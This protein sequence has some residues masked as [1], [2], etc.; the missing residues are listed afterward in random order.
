MNGAVRSSVRMIRSRNKKGEDGFLIDVRVWLAGGPKL[1]QRLFC[2]GVK[3]DA[4]V[5]GNRMLNEMS[6]ALLGGAAQE[7]GRL[8]P[9]EHRVAVAIPPSTVPR[10][11]E[12][13][14]VFLRDYV[15]ANKRAASTYDSYEY[16]LRLYIV[17]LI[18]DLRLNEVGRPA[19]TKLKAALCGREA[20]SVNDVLGVLAK[21]LDFAVSEG[22][23][24]AMPFR[25]KDVKLP[26]VHHQ[27]E[28]YDFAEFERLV[29]A[30][31]ALGPH[32]Y[33][34]VLLGGEAGL[35]RGE[36]AALQWR[37]IDLKSGRL[38]VA[39]SLYKGML[40]PPKGRKSRTMQ[41][42]ERLRGALTTLSSRFA[43]ERVVL[44]AG[45]PCNLGT[46]NEILGHVSKAAG[47]KKK[48]SRKV[49]I[50][51]HTFCSHLAMRGATAVQIQQLAGH[52][53]LKTTQGY[54][55]LAPGHAD[56]AIELLNGRA[57]PTKQASALVTLASAAQSA[58]MGS[59][60]R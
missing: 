7:M 29:E 53:D 46:V 44:H 31:F 1:R 16:R 45:K 9:A 15:R 52:V 42:T 26:E 12:F 20:G 43:G 36:I 3:A 25:L 2:E 13:A 6:G 4:T 48:G 8:H 18:G 33:A 10:L 60:Q 51:R 56:Q 34:T 24:P 35:R 5:F 19:V 37:E 41:M 54:M 55:H 27:P 49:H 22:L 17:P 50:L 14:D 59:N 57:V 58:P 23:I 28:F 38:T 11:R 21:M 32:E 30:A 40:G 47:L 39:W